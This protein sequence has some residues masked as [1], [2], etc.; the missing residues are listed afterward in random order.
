LSDDV[1]FLPQGELVAWLT[2][3]GGAIEIIEHVDEPIVPS[4]LIAWWS[5]IFRLN[6][7]PPSLERIGKVQFYFTLYVA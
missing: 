3:P 2:V 4:W 7:S 5:L 1:R 6:A